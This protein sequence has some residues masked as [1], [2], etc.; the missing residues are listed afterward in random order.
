MKHSSYFYGKVQSL[1]L[2]TEKGNATI[3]VITPGKYTFNTASEETM[4]V[5]SGSLKYRLPGKEWQTAA[6]GRSFI[7]PEKSSFDV[8]AGD[9]AAYICYYK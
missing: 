1:S 8:E 9:D 2:S 7:A 5:V 4:C 6:Q 3:G